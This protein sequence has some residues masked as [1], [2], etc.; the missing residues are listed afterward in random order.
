[1]TI[2]PAFAV[3]C[4]AGAR[5]RYFGRAATPSCSNFTRSCG[6]FFK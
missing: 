6:L 1:M 3:T 2:S 4:F 5:G